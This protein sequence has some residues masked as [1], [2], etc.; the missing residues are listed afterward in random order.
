MCLLFSTQKLCQGFERSQR[1]GE[2]LRH[3]HRLTRG[4]GGK[5][6]QES[7]YWQSIRLS[8]HQTHPG[9]L[10]D[11]IYFDDVEIDYFR[12]CSIYYA[13]HCQVFDPS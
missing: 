5:T 12:R 3:L 7:T 4:S 6:D 10:E 8:R 11:Y 2:R 1:G 13:R 9:S